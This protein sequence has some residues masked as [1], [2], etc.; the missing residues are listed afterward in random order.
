MTALGNIQA[1]E[2]YIELNDTDT[3][4]EQAIKKL[5]SHNLQ[6][7]ERDLAEVREKLEHFEEKYNMPSEKFHECFH[8]GKF[9]DDEDFF[10]WD[11]LFETSKRLTARIYLLKGDLSAQA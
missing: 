2:K 6:K 1:L 5:I 4:T 9:G 10:I 8:H 3:F 11:A 7:E